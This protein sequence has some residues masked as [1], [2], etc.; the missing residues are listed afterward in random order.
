MKF[1]GFVLEVLSF[2]CTVASVFPIFPFLTWEFSHGYL[3]SALSLHV[4]FVNEW[5]REMGQ[6]NTKSFLL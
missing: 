1:Y 2:L 4:G 3:V 6:V 5:S